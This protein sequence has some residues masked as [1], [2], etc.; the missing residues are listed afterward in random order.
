MAALLG[1]KDI[2][3][4]IRDGYRHLFPA[5]DT[6]PTPEERARQ[7]ELDRLKGFTYFDTFAQ[8]E[9][10]SRADSDPTQRANTPILPRPQPA[11]KDDQKAAVLLCH[12]YSGNYHDYE[13]VQQRGVDEE[14]YTCE[15]LQYVD[16]FIYFS[17]KLVCVPPPSWTIALHRNGVQSLGTLLIEPQTKDADRLLLRAGN[18]ASSRD[19]MHFPIARKLADLA[20]HCGFDGWLVNIEKPFS[21][22]SWDPRI[23]EAFLRQL[24]QNLGPSRCLI[25][26]NALTTKNFS[27]SEACGRVLTNYSWKESDALSSKRL[28]LSCKDIPPRHLFF[29]ID[30]WA[31]NKTPLTRRRITYPEKDGGGT[32]IGVAVSKLSELD[33]S[34]GIFA[35][36]WTFEHFSGSYSHEIEKSVWE[37]YPL[38]DGI[39]CACGD[40]RTQH[41]SSQRRGIVHYATHYPA[42]SATFFY[43]DFSRGFGRHDYLE[44]AKLYGGKQM[45]AQVSSQSILPH[46]IGPSV[47]DQFRQD[48]NI[49]SR[50]LEDPLGRTRLA[51]ETYSAMPRGDDMVIYERSLPLFKLDMPSNGSLKLDVT[52]HDLLQTLDATLSLYMKFNNGVRLLP[53][54]GKH[55]I[56]CLVELEDPPNGSEGGRLQELGIHLRAPHMG[57]EPRRL[58]E[59]QYIRIITHRHVTHDCTTIG[60]IRIVRRGD[61]DTEH[62]R[63]CWTYDDGNEAKSRTFDIPYSDITGPFSYFLIKVDGVEL[64]RVYALEYILPT[65]LILD[66]SGEPLAKVD[67]HVLGVGFDGEKIARRSETVLTCEEK[68]Q[69]KC[70]AVKRQMGI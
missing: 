46:A 26:S 13:S 66:S 1:W 14:S 47:A 24:K 28:A 67:V 65:A 56:E 35:P 17:H 38:P 5:P 9:A 58:L 41:P 3:R 52:F 7:R 48:V 27:F 25:W 64:G 16:T 62:W 23:L 57:E 49:L 43:T 68:I 6:G 45:H 39:T 55:N 21:I 33:L 15:Y 2:L 8:L 19:E 40:Y 37:G 70:T 36:A 50:K 30:V 12:D 53:C 60:N 10:W 4:P 69:L 63:L 34:A 59:I 11:S 42:G 18:V 44:A 31:Q 29:G 22:P 32:N 51:I 61:K 54:K 20:E